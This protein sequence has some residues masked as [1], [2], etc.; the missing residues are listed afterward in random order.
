MSQYIGKT[1]S[2]ISVTDNRYVGTLEKI[3]S[4][5]GTVTL[6]NVRCF[7]TEGRKNWGPDEIYPNPTV[8]QS[9]QFNGNDVKDLSILEVKPE[10]VFPILPPNLTAFPFSQQSQTQPQPQA[11]V[12]GQPQTQTQVQQQQQQQQRQPISQTPQQQEAVLS[13]SSGQNQVQPVTTQETPQNIPAAMAAYGVY[14]PTGPTTTTTLSPPTTEILEDQSNINAMPVQSYGEK[15]D[16]EHRPRRR[17]PRHYSRN[18]AIEIPTNDFDFESNN[19]RFAQQA[20]EIANEHINH[21]KSDSNALGEI[22]H[23]GLYYDKKTSF[24]DTISTSAEV[25]T[26]MRWKEEKL[27]NLDTFGQSS[28]RPRYHNNGGR[29]GRGNYR[30][31]NRNNYRGNYRSGPR[32]SRGG[33]GRNNYQNDQF[34]RR[35]DGNDFTP[36]EALF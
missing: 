1:I 8:Y 33:R 15:R 12:Q 11:Q 23:E 29:G 30:G 24:F 36:N 4:E 18:K 32:S 3:N 35:P 22:D 27:L 2:L 34:S 21:G 14:A 5:K 26:N 16:Y 20:P 10:E 6:K 31:G 19:A 13:P 7:G 25:N 9:V 17:Q 28:A